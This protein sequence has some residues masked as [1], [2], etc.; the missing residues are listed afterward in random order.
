MPPDTTGR[1]NDA[2]VDR[3]VRFADRKNA[4]FSKPVTVDGVTAPVHEE[5]LA[6]LIN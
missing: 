6:K 3:L 5:G 4:A 1:L 2:D